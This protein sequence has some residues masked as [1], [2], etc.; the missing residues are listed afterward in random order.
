MSFRL[1]QFSPGPSTRIIRMRAIPQRWFAPSPYTP[2][3]GFLR[4]WLEDDDSTVKKSINWGA[5]SGLALSLAVSSAF[6]MGLALTVE[7][8]WK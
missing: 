2:Q 4:L 6:W 1:L 5:I 3:L 8:I 7:R